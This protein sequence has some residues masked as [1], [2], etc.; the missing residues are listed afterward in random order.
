MRHI[1]RLAKPTEPKGGGG[2]GEEK[3]CL[4]AVK[5]FRNSSSRTNLA[6]LHRTTRDAVLSSHS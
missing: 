1:D 4:S 2:E 5:A 6:G 3:A